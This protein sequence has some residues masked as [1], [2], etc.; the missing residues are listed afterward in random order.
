MEIQIN[1]DGYAYRIPA[2]GPP[3]YEHRW[4]AEI[5]LGRRLKFWEEV[6]HINGRRCDNRAE[7][8]CVMS[9]WNHRR[10]HRWQCW[11]FS[12]IG[13]YPR[14]ETRIDR[15]RSYFGGILVGDFV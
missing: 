15:L 6:H 2:Y 9:R 3:K 13:K 4:V 5:F 11:M 14:L 8:L 12:S 1:Q 10:Y 7:N